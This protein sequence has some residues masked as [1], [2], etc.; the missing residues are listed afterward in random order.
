MPTAP[1]AAAPLGPPFSPT[2]FAHP[3]LPGGL[4]FA[5]VP[6]SLGG[7]L[8]LVPRGL[9]LSPPR[10]TAPPPPGGSFYFLDQLKPPP[11]AP[12]G[13][14]SAPFPGA[15]VDLGL[16]PVEHRP[17]AIPTLGVAPAGPMKLGCLQ[18]Q[19]RVTLAVARAKGSQAMSIKMIMGSL[20]TSVVL[21]SC[22]V[23]DGTSAQARW[24]RIAPGGDSAQSA[25]SRNQERARAWRQEEEGETAS[26]ANILPQGGA[27]PEQ[28]PAD[29]LRQLQDQA[30]F[31]MKQ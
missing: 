4:D 13:A 14:A 24:S 12:R 25:L 2:T 30:R 17:E 6:Q 7:A 27:S 5:A 8:S 16:L 1:P 19:A 28:L 18:D 15:D 22:A 9:S 29:S 3:G 21:C 11:A 26:P 23:N 31:W 20:A 10:E